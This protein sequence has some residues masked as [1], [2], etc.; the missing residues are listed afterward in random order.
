[1]SRRTKGHYPFSLKF[2]RR[3]SFHI[4]PLADNSQS[5]SV[6]FFFCSRQEF[7]CQVWKNTVLNNSHFSETIF[8]QLR[9]SY[10]DRGIYSFPERRISGWGGTQWTSSLFSPHLTITI[11]ESSE[12]YHPSWPPNTSTFPLCQASLVSSSPPMRT[13]PWACGDD[14]PSRRDAAEL[15]AL[16]RCERSGDI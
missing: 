2:N 11:P 8:L 6:R 13:L 7:L 14:S 4:P 16:W 12:A 3:E 15:K 1:M 5:R 10:R 9:N